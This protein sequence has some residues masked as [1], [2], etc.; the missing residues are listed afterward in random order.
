M[1]IYDN[2]IMYVPARASGLAQA[3]ARTGQDRRTPLRNF[4]A[5]DLI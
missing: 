1:Y 3:R 4:L 2:I 5:M